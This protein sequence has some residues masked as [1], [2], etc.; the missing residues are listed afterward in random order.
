MITDISGSHG[1]VSVEEIRRAVHFFAQTLLPECYQ[2]LY[3][4]IELTSN[5]SEKGMACR[6]SKYH[7]T[8]EASKYQGAKTLISTLAHEMVHVKQ[9]V[10]GELG[11][12][13]NLYKWNGIVFPK[14]YDYYDAPWEIE[15]YGREVG[16]SYK[17]RVMEKARG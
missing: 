13:K 5:R 7:Y 17:F 10:N 12:Q 15:A 16:L 6:E 3:I 1:L 14:D 11:Y 2:K 8:I 4:E 9:F